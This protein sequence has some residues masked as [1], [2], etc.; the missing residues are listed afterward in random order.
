MKLPTELQIMGK[1][2]KVT[3]TNGLKDEDGDYSSGLCDS[4]NNTIHI[5]TKENTTEEEILSTLGHEM[6]HFVIAKS[7]LSELIGDKE[8][9]LVIVLEEHLLPLF[10]HNRKKWRKRK[11]VGDVS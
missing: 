3:Y 4:G 11:E 8:E 9:S 2:V 10:S 6:I 7:G 5:C 1:K